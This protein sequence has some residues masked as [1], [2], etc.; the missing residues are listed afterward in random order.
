MHRRIMLIVTL[1][2]LASAGAAVAAENAVAG[3]WQVVS[4]SPGGEQYNW[5]LEIKEE[6]GKLSGTLAGSPGQ[7]ALLDLRF[8]NDTLTCKVTIDEQTYA[9]QMKVDGAKIDGTWKGPSSQ[10]TIK[11]NKQ[12]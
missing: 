1:A 3:T 6:N 2:A 5:K 10:G 8:E 12:A 9:I 11:G 4:D 7:F